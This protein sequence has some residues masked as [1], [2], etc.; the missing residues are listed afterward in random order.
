MI[1]GCQQLSEDFI[2]EFQND[3]DLIWWRI[4]KF[5]RLSKEFII[6]FSDK[7]NFDRILIN[8]KISDEVKE[9][10]RMFI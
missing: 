7:I 8:E 10:Y 5:Q 1:C 2:R 3:K 9:F 6:E 4:S